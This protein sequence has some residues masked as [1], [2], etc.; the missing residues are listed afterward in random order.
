MGLSDRKYYY[1]R[2][3]QGKDSMLEIVNKVFK[4]WPLIVF[5]VG[6]VVTVQLMRFQVADHDRRILKLEATKDEWIKR[7]LDR[8]RHPR[9]RPD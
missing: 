1:P 6:G 4:F 9:R 7:E 5:L 2:L 3:K 8:P